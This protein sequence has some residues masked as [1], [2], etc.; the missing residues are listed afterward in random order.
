MATPNVLRR[1]QSI[2][3]ESWQRRSRRNLERAPTCN[4]GEARP[5]G[6]E[7][8]S[9][10]T[11]GYLPISSRPPSA[12]ITSPGIPLSDKSRRPITAGPLSRLCCS[13]RR[14]RLG[15]GV[16]LW[17]AFCPSLGQIAAELNSAH[18]QHLRRLPLA[19]A[20]AA[21][22]CRRLVA[23]DYTKVRK[24]RIPLGFRKLSAR[25]LL[26]KKWGN[27]KKC[28]ET[29]RQT[30]PR[31]HRI[32]AHGNEKTERLIRASLGLRVFAFSGVTPMRIF[33][34][35]NFRVI[36]TKTA[37]LLIEILK[38]IL[39]LSRQIPSWG[40]PA[41]DFFALLSTPR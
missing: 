3:W 15:G 18:P 35:P 36:V 40:N 37:D 21:L 12:C 34:D 28:P 10:A 13:G 14:F 9:P 1:A 31:M 25:K 33:E 27:L 5:L 7:P 8:N 41:R 22:L 6:H 16:S 32:Q 26:W 20:E 23:Q 39:S 11:P 38:S 24:L 19:Q 30:P 29:A 2:K 4:L 17:D